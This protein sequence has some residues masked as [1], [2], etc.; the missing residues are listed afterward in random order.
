M[1]Y[2]P[3]CGK[4][5]TMVLSNMEGAPFTLENNPSIPRGDALYAA[6]DESGPSVLFSPCYCLDCSGWFAVLGIA[7]DDY[8]PSE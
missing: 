1:K 6:I 4:Q 3:R 8:K 7:P 5:N 2:C